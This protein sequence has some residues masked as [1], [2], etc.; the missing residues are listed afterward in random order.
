[1]S[2]P[3]DNNFEP[4]G[5]RRSGWVPKLTK[6]DFERIWEKA[7]ETVRPIVEREMG[8]SVFR[9]TDQP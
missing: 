4:V 2:T 8:G 5:Y 9:P 1:M 7:R 3:T 6:E